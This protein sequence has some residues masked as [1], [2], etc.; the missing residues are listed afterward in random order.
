M[1]MPRELSKN[2]D[3]YYDLEIAKFLLKKKIND[4]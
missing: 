2:I 1:I 3:D 4:N